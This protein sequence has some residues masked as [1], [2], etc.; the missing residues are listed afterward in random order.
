MDIAFSFDERI[1]SHVHVP[2]ESILQQHPEDQVTFWIMT[3][4]ESQDVLREPLHRQLDGR[5]R[6]EMLDSGELFRSLPQSSHLR[7]H[8]VSAGMYLKLLIA[9]A[10]PRWVSRILYL[11]VDVLCMSSLTELWEADL[12]GAA[13]GA[14]QD[15]GAPTIGSRGG[16][17]KTPD[18][19]R[20]DE[21]YFNSGVLLIDTRE[22][23]RAQLTEKSFAYISELSSD[24]RYPD[25]DALNVAAHKR[26]S[27][28]DDKWNHMV[29]YNDDRR[30]H[31]GLFHF[32]GL[33][34]PWDETYPR[35]ELRA[36][37]VSLLDSATQM[38]AGR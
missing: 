35:A 33:E 36:R 12:G 34:K 9:K 14:V 7:L 29:N 27:S 15:F 10:T 17:P 16:L 38:L 20:P 30:E 18:H 8:R 19:I 23:L 5:A 31:T 2:I 11:D 21:P 22:W 24:L 37:Y 26:W 32:A 25:Q 1:A 13:L 4:K 6:F 3:T 28:L